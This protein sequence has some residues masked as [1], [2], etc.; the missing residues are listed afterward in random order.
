M[1]MIMTMIM[2]IQHNC[3]CPSVNLPSVSFSANK[4]SSCPVTL[5]PST[6]TS[7]LTTGPDPLLSHMSHDVSF[8]SDEPLPGDF[9]SGFLEGY[10]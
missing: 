8:I 10:W 1:I 4:R 3:A 7:D 5:L 6:S 9:G 2:I